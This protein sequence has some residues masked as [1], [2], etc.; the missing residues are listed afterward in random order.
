MDPNND[1]NL[2]T[3]LKKSIKRINKDYE[4]I[5]CEADGCDEDGITYWVDCKNGYTGRSWDV[6]GEI[7]YHKKNIY[8]DISKNGFKFID[9]TYYYDHE[10]LSELILS[11]KFK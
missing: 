4:I 3:H 5:D 10:K 11:L 6:P 7:C 8:E 2:M 9:T 1:I